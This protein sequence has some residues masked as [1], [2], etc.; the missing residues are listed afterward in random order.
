MAGLPS[1]PLPARHPGPVEPALNVARVC[2]VA[3]ALDIA[4][5]VARA[6]KVVEDVAALVDLVD[7]LDWGGRT[8][9]GVPL[10][11]VLVLEAVVLLGARLQQRAA[12]PP[13]GERS[14]VMSNPATSASTSGLPASLAAE[15]AGRAVPGGLAATWVGAGRCRSRIIRLRTLSRLLAELAAIPPRLEVPRGL[16]TIG[17]QANGANVGGL[18][19][20]A[21]V[22]ARLAV[23][24]ELA[25]ARPGA[26]RLGPQLLNLL[27]ERVPCTPHGVLP[28]P[29]LEQVERSAGLE[30]DQASDE[31]RPLFPLRD[32]VADEHEL[33][34]EPVGALAVGVV[35]PDVIAASHRVVL[36]QEC[37]VRLFQ[38]LRH[39]R[40]GCELRVQNGAHAP[41]VVALAP[42]GEVLEALIPP[43]QHEG[44]VASQI[45]EVAGDDP[46]L[47]RLEG[48]FCVPELVL[49]VGHVGLVRNEPDL[50]GR[51]PEVAEEARAA[52]LVALLFFIGVVEADDADAIEL[53]PGVPE[54]HRVGLGIDWRG[55][56]L[57]QLQCLVSAVQTAIYAGAARRVAAAGAGAGAG[58]AW[59]GGAARAFPRRGRVA[60]AAVRR[61]VGRS[62]SCCPSGGV[63]GAA[64]VAPALALP[65][66]VVVLMDVLHHHGCGLPRI[67]GL[68]CSCCA[69]GRS[70]GTACW[71]LSLSHDRDAL[72]PRL[73]LVFVRAA[74]T[75]HGSKVT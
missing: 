70:A 7:G 64:A 22:L 10:A 63:S 31:A 39:S 33:H 19:V 54:D 3:E 37:V 62:A 5:A 47:E 25:A 32:F 14:G 21:A 68:W 74:S 12:G 20:L 73:D 56:G 30:V 75:A 15:L 71:D 55:R 4:Y 28:L 24:G 23:V 9:A 49:P 43:L 57:L 35:R 52:D 65:G 45:L 67:C 60:A 17:R 58:A 11:F 46:E 51:L 59:G 36:Q 50:L 34:A 42:I 69:C 53:A 26:E 1:V 2:A 16:A 27:H 6:V 41:P 29:R 8:P 61:R 18:A 48:G 66:D 40:L 13:R 72:L 44:L 38:G